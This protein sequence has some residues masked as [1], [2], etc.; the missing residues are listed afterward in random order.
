MKVNYE[1]NWWLNNASS[2]RKLNFFFFV[3]GFVTY[4]DGL[5]IVDNADFFTQTNFTLDILNYFDKFL[6]FWKRNK[7]ETTKIIS[8]SNQSQILLC[9]KMYSPLYRNV[10]TINAI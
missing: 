2:Y 10:C 5:L 4:F 1:S 6:D 9:S 8:R 3:S 7:Q